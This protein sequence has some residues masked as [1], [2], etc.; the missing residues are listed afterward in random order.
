LAGEVRGFAPCLPDVHSCGAA[1]ESARSTRT[2]SGET[3]AIALFLKLVVD[4]FVSENDT[5]HG[6]RVV[7]RK[8]MFMAEGSVG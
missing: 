3:E 2:D 1:E 5:R 6:H 7:L 4:I 8:K